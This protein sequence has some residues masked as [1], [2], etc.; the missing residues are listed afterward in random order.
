MSSSDLIQRLLA[1]CQNEYTYDADKEEAAKEIKA[2]VK[3]IAVWSENY[4]AL[5]RKLSRIDCILQRAVD[6]YGR[7][8]R[9]AKDAKERRDWQSMLIA[10]VDIRAAALK[11]LGGDA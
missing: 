10:A 11:P 7:K 1:P 3:E 9:E 2:Q 6:G 8:M 5:E 4:A